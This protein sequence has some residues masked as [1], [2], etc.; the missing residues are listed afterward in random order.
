[1]RWLYQ[2]AAQA[3]ETA[4]AAAHGAAAVE[5]AHAG[6]IPPPV[7]EAN[8]DLLTALIASNFMG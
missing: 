3:Q 4:I 8:R 5:A 1:M 2:A 6:V 7:I